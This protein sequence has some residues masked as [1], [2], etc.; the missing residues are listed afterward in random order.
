MSIAVKPV[1]MSFYYLRH[2]FVSTRSDKDYRD[3]ILGRL[4]VPS[5]YQFILRGKWF[6]SIKLPSLSPA[7]LF[8]HNPWVNITLGPSEEIWRRK[9][10][11]RINNPH[12]NHPFNPDI[13]IP[14]TICFWKIMKKI[15]K[16]I[17]ETA[18]PVI[19]NAQLVR[20]SLEK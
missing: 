6:R 17:V 2:D 9:M 5:L 8:L 16:G 12:D 10:N 3:I 1:G 15:I 14:F 7:S 18:A 20:F 19:I 4:F 11:V 13:A